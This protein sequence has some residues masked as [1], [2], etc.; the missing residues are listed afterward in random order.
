M[1]AFASFIAG[2]V[3]GLGLVIS[4]MTS[5]DKVFGF[6]DIAGQWDPSLAFVMG[7]AVMTATPI[8]WLA[9]RRAKPV[10]SAS[11]DTP[12]KTPVD[13]RLLG[14]AV[15][16]GIGWGLSGICPGP[17]LVSAAITPLAI[18]GFVIAMVVG[19]VFSSRVLRPLLDARQTHATL[20][21][22]AIP[23]E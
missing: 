23:A 11:F 7:G 16:F 12:P 17:A 8:F 10:V 9:R 20:P 5:P 6:L 1:R 14:G 22:I 18:G 21:E 3:F 15:L 4:G 13:R 2:L 19:I